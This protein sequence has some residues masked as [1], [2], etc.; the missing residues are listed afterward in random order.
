MA[1]VISLT[2]HDG[3]LVEYVDSIIGQGGMKDVYFSPDK[4]Y[5]VCFFRTKAD[6]ATRDR[7]LTIAAAYRLERLPLEQLRPYIEDL[8]SVYY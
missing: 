7:L 8:T 4:S 6:A 2:A 3:S 5:V 1:N